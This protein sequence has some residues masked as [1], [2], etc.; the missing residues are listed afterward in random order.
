MKKRSY[1]DPSL[2]LD[3]KHWIVSINDR[4]PNDKD[5][6]FARIIIEGILNQNRFVVE[7]QIEHEEN[8]KIKTITRK[9]QDIYRLGYNQKYTISYIA[10]PKECMALDT[11]L[12]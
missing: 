9:I 5:A 4:P 6:K 12:E 7:Y 11:H 2:W 8:K 10:I 3:E 1:A